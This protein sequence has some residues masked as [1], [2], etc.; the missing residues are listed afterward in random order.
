[1]LKYSNLQYAGVEF[2]NNDRIHGAGG[3]N[4][5]GATNFAINTTGYD[6]FHVNVRLRMQTSSAFNWSASI[7]RR[8]P[9]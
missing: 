2:Y 1:M 4:V 6:T 7:P 8:R 9:R 5:G 3:D